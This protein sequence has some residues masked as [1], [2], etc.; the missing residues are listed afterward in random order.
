MCVCWAA[1]NSSPR[2]RSHSRINAALVI[3]GTEPSSLYST[4]NKWG[5]GSFSMNSFS[6]GVSVS[7]GNLPLRASRESSLPFSRNLPQLGLPSAVHDLKKARHS[8]GGNHR[9]PPTGANGDTEG[10]NEKS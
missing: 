6:I 9:N 1:E 10:A 2:L 8:P 7:K 3:V 4:E 5:R